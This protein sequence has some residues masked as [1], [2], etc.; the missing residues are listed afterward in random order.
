[1]IPNKTM[2]KR[3]KKLK[4]LPK[5]LQESLRKEGITSDYRGTKPR[6]K[7][8]KHKQEKTELAPLWFDSK[9]GVAFN[10]GNLYGV[11]KVYNPAKK[12]NLTTKKFIV[13]IPL[14]INKISRRDNEYV[15]DYT[16]INVDDSKPLDDFITFVSGRAKLTSKTKELFTGYINAYIASQEE[17]KRIDVQEAPIMVDAD[18]IIRITYDLEPMLPR[19]GTEEILRALVNFREHASNQHTFDSAFGFALTAPL[20]YEFRARTRAD[21]I[22][23]LHI[24]YGRTGSGKTSILALFVEQGFD[25]RKEECIMSLQ[26]VKT[27]FT[28]LKMLSDGNLPVIIDDTNLQ[29]VNDLSEELK[30]LSG[31]AIAGTRGRADQ[32]VRQYLARRGLY[33]TLNEHINRSDNAVLSRRDILEEFTEKHARRVNQP[34]FDKLREYLPRGFM[35]FLLKEI[36]H[37][38]KID[39]IAKEIQKCKTPADF[40]NYGLGKVNELCRLFDLPEFPKYEDEKQTSSEGPAETLCEF[41]LD[42]WER[43]TSTDDQGRPHAPYPKVSKTELD[44]KKLDCGGY[45]ISFTGAAYRIAKNEMKLG[46]PTATDL[47]NNIVESP[48][49]KIGDQMKSHYFNGTSLKAFSLYYYGGG[50]DEKL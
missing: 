12:E 3:K 6:T 31:S 46:F 22:V 9:N 36:F 26:S 20:H 32:T 35:F 14:K 43:L 45:F 11:K 34:A 7:K 47:V 50:S 15:I 48:S 23:P 19:I 13:H 27:R 30:N 5:D 49:L 39:N 37:D 42:Q 41:F 24:D 40:V 18:G 38:V 16:W 4:D 1:M 28:W 8:A 25:Q 44:I 10:D 21:F 33:I 2:K 17:A 29:W